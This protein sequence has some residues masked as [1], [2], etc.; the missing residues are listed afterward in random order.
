MGDSPILMKLDPDREKKRVLYAFALFFLSL[1]KIESGLALFLDDLQWLDEDGF[2]LL[3]ELVHGMAGYP[4]LIIGAYRDTEVGPEHRL[5]RFTHKSIWEE[6][7][8]TSIH[9]KSLGKEHLNQLV[10]ELF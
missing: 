4:F 2:D 9:L 6:H 3:H 7:A 10:E 8:L 1:A 5:N